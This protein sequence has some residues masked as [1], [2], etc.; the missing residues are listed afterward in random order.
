MISSYRYCGTILSDG[1]RFTT[2]VML[3]NS[4]QKLPK[5][6]IIKVKKCFLNLYK[7]LCIRKL[8]V[9]IRGDL[10]GVKL[11]N[12]AQI[13]SDREIPDKVEDKLAILR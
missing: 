12:L 3:E 11:G 10:V 8:K 2:V 13:N 9:V 7:T 5:F 1:Q 4:F 6:T